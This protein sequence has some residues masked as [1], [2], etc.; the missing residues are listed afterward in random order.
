M[1]YQNTNQDQ[2]IIEFLEKVENLYRNNKQD[3]NRFYAI[4]T[5]TIWKLRQLEQTSK[6]Y[7]NILKY[8]WNVPQFKNLD[9]FE[10]RYNFK[11]IEDYV[12]L[13]R[14]PTINLIHLNQ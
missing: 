6:I 11:L 4:I 7:L 10:W 12:I 3:I 8:I 1:L 5:E 13:D 9:T 2:I 14:Q